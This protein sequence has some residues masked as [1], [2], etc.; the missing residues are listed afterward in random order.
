MQIGPFAVGTRVRIQGSSN[1]PM[2]IGGKVGRIS[3]L[4]PGGAMVK[5]DDREEKVNVRD[6]SMTLEKGVNAEIVDA[7]GELLKLVGGPNHVFQAGKLKEVIHIRIKCKRKESPD[8][9]TATVTTLLAKWAEIVAQAGVRNNPTV[10]VSVDHLELDGQRLSSR[11][12]FKWAENGSAISAVGTFTIG[13]P[14]KAYSTKP[15][16]DPNQSAC[17]CVQ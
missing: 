17:C 8:T 10:V 2:A 7:N 3:A 6:T 5:L 13:P 1:D 9:L 4:I 11:D 16:Q 15:Y 12:P 14:N